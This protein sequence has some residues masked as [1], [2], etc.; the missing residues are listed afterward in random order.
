MFLYI[1]FLKFGLIYK[2]ERKVF[3][4]KNGKKIYAVLSLISQPIARKLK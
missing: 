4:V 3:L 2:F 1:L